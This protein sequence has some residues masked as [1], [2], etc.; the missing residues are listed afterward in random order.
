MN[1]LLRVLVINLFLYNVYGQSCD[2]S[3]CVSYSPSPSLTITPTPDP[4]PVMSPDPQPVMSPDSPQPCSCSSPT[5]V[6]TYS[7]PITTTPS[8]VTLTNSPI[9]VSPSMTASISPSPVTTTASN[10][11]FPSTTPSPT[12]TTLTSSPIYV[13]PSPSP[14]TTPTPSPVV[15]TNSP[16]PISTSLPIVT[17]TLS[18]PTSSPPQSSC[19]PP[20]SYVDDDWQDAIGTAYAEKG[21]VDGECSFNGWT[22]V[23]PSNQFLAYG[24]N[25]AALAEPHYDNGN[26]CGSCFEMRC[27]EYTEGC[28]DENVIIQFAVTDSTNSCN[29]N[30]DGAITE[31]WCTQVFDTDT[32]WHF[33]FIPQIWNSISNSTDGMRLK[34]RR[35]ACPTHEYLHVITRNVNGWKSVSVAGLPDFGGSSSFGILDSNGTFIDMTQWKPGAAHYFTQESM[36]PYELQITLGNGEIVETTDDCIDIPDDSWPDGSLFNCTYN[37]RTGCAVDSSPTTS[38]YDQSQFLPPSP[39]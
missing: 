32:D 13:S 18:E 5:V 28:V 21:V 24:Y 35:I 26:M 4:P 20:S 6:S 14:S 29:T 36:G 9:Y 34:F 25:V 38:I 8:P 10:S 39:Q 15:I 17:T 12:I 37:S 7:D 3:C 11:P 19:A 22:S 23:T 1:V 2:C 30:D 31:N 16:I 33:D 27:E